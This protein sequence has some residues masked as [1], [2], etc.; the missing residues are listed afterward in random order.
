MSTSCVCSICLSDFVDPVCTP[1]GYVYC[2]RCITEAT[3]IKRE[4]GSV[5]APCPT[6]RKSFSINDDPV[7]TPPPCQWAENLQNISSSRDFH[8]YLGYPLRRLYVN[9]LRVNFED[10]TV[11]DVL[12]FVLLALYPD[13][14]EILYR[15]IKTIILGRRGPT[16][17]EMPLFAHSMTVLFE[18]LRS[19]PVPQD[20]VV[21]I[22][23]IGLYY[24][25]RYWKGAEMFS[26]PSR[27]LGDRPREASVPFSRCAPAYMGRKYVLK[28]QVTQ[29]STV[30]D[31]A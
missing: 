27:F 22:D 15:H 20:T 23:V 29:R 17:E 1:C 13:Q 7:R 30:D 16:Y 5:T 11:A 26:D 12:A 14:Q 10:K 9:G 4:E 3:N 24:N 25:P 6:C 18:T 28:N 21:S 8:E 31:Y 19:F 2:S